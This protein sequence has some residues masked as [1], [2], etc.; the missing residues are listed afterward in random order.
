M[1][2]EQ[3]EKDLKFITFNILELKSK[4]KMKDS[5]MMNYVNVAV[6]MK[7][8]YEIKLKEITKQEDTHIIHS[9]NLV[10]NDLELNLS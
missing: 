10:N 7:Q 9:Y 2:F 6:E 1:D 5:D 8:N 4:T 3:D